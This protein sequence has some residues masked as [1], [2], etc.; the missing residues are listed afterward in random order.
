MSFFETPIKPGDSF[1]LNGNAYVFPLGKFNGVPYE[2]GKAARVY[3]IIRNDTS[4][5]ALK[6]FFKE[7]QNDSIIDIN[8]SFKDYL[9]L[10]GLKVAERV[11][12]T[13]EDQEVLNR[14]PQFRDAVLM[15]WVAG[16][17][18]QNFIIDREE[19]EFLDGLNLS[20][21]LAQ[22]FTE[23]EKRHL[24]HCDLSNGNFVFSPDFSNVELVDIEEMYGDGF[25]PPTPLP[26]GTDGYAPLRVVEDG[27]YGPDA[28]RLSLSILIVEILCWQFE[29]VRQAREPMSLFASDEFG[30]LSKRYKLVTDK[31]ST[32]PE[33][34]G[35]NKEKILQLFNQAWFSRWKDYD[36]KV[37]YSSIKDM[38]SECPL[39]SDWLDALGKQHHSEEH[40]ILEVSDTKI[41]FGTIDL[42]KKH[43]KSNSIII[44][45][46]GTGTLLGKSFHSLGLLFLLRLV[47]HFQ[48][49][50][51]YL[52]M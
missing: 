12:I 34:S 40:P 18:W 38:Y 25:S 8:R 35:V 50:R 37:E 11:V 9:D 22:I 10:P 30:Y 39:A 44:K 1:D 42:D 36:Q 21:E 33:A 32:L 3:Q 6:V 28:D 7:Y 14:Y 27:Y 23:F 52:L 2:V 48:R 24:A 26:V 13:T 41:D 46:V 29:E 51:S 19:V 5:Y 4:L 17:S 47:L 31:L 20:R 16:K 43:Q 45:N 49:K 15:P